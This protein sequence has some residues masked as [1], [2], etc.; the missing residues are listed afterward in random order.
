MH[1]SGCATVSFPGDLS[2]ASLEVNQLPLSPA[3][4]ASYNDVEM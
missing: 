2:P 4:S 1:T 3:E